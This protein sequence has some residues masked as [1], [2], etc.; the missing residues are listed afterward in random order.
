MKTFKESIEFRKFNAKISK[1]TLVPEHE[2]NYEH[3]P[4]L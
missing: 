3:S 1:E 4:R 2:Y